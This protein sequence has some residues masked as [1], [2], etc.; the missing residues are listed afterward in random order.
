MILELNEANK[1]PM[2]TF[3][4]LGVNELKLQEE[5]PEIRPFK[6]PE[7][8]GINT[9]E[10]VITTG[11]GYTTKQMPPTG[12]GEEAAEFIH[13]HKNHEMTLTVRKGRKVQ[14][15]VFINYSLDKTNPVLLE[16]I[17]IFA[18]ENSEVTLVVTYDGKKD[19]KAY[20]GG[21]LYLIAGKNALIKLIQIQLLPDSA[22]HFVNIGAHLE[23]GG[24]IHIT[25]CELGGSRAISGIMGELTGREC[26]FDVETIYFGDKERSLDFNYVAN[27]YGKGSRSNMKVNGALFNNSKKIFRGTIDFKKGASGASGAEEEYILL[28]DKGIKNVSVPLIL[29]GEEDVSGKHAAN[30]GRIDED[31]LF[32]MMS[33]GLNEEEAKKMML[34]AWFQPA[35]QNIPS[36]EMKSRVSD[37]V[38]ERLDHDKS[39]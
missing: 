38:K 12:M 14:E 1:L 24:R 34:E 22:L 19:E 7:L 27:H 17:F 33:R 26:E 4:W 35:L 25:Q 8:Q 15:P 18:E 39:I 31:K 16:E 28:F 36:E 29:C 20:H 3:R 23:D 9:E 32:Y 6:M 30:S 10:L 11:N 2:K 37:Y 13:L 5:L 21:L